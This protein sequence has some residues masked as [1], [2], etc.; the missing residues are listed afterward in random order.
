MVRQNRAATRP[1]DRGYFISQP[2]IE[3]PTV[4]PP[5]STAEFL[6]LVRGS[7]ILTPSSVEEQLSAVSDTSEPLRAAE[8]LVRKGILTQFQVKQLLAGRHRG[9]RLGSY[10]IQDLLG[11]GGMGSVY[12]A[13]HTALRRRVA[14]KVLR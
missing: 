7:G 10:V 6:D 3:M 5:A 8:L 14:L 13:E 1:S 4:T 9:F 2:T 11:Q 12:L